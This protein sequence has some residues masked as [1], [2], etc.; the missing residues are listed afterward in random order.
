MKKIFSVFIV[1]LFLMFVLAGSIQAAE[2]FLFKND[3]VDLELL[4]VDGKLIINNGDQEIAL[5][6]VVS[7]SGAKYKKDD[8]MFWS[9][10]NDGLLEI[11]GELISFSDDNY[12][13][14]E[15]AAKN[16]V[17]FRAVGNEPGWYVEIRDDVD[18]KF[19]GDYGET[20]IRARVN[21]VWVGPAGDDKIYY[22][23]SP[24]VKFQVILIKKQY[25]DSMNGEK[26]PYQ[27]RIIFPDE[28]Y[29]GGGR[30][31]TQN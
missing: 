7:A 26:L 15:I 18:V 8:L 23:D 5:D 17:D 11:K 1:T 24:I 9:K 27:V 29:I 28:S 21:D 13:S 4:Y 10:E 22:I 14:W 30:L 19:V 31:L 20:E 2:R 12:N 6:S 3:L 16:G 25:I